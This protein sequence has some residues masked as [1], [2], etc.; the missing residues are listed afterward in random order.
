MILF[1]WAG[2]RLTSLTVDS[3]PTGNMLTFRRKDSCSW[4]TI[5]RV[6]YLQFSPKLF[7]RTA[8]SHRF[9]ICKNICNIFILY[10]F[11]RYKEN[12]GYQINFDS[13]HFRIF[14]LFFN[15]VKRVHSPEFEVLGIFLIS[16]TIQKILRNEKHFFNSAYIILVIFSTF[17]ISLQEQ[18]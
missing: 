4:S 13:A 7:H 6:R 18:L 16:H 9:Q 3:L 11:L 5:L 1:W 14:L 10:V 12:I 8:V 17:S 2:C 15:S